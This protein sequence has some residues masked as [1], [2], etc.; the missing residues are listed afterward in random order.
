[1]DY[2]ILVERREIDGSN[3]KVN[4]GELPVNSA[5]VKLE[6]SRAV[7]NA[8]FVTRGGHDVKTGDIISFISDDLPV[9]NLACAYNFHHNLRDEGGYNIDGFRI[10]G[11]NTG[12]NYSSDG[13]YLYSG[14]YIEANGLQS[15]FTGATTVSV[16]A[17]IKMV[18]DNTDT[19]IVSMW[20]GTSND[21]DKVFDIHVNGSSK[22]ELS[23]RSG[24]T[25]YITTGT[26]TLNQ[27]TLYHV[28][29]T[30]DGSSTTVKLYLNGSEE[31]SDSSNPSSLATGTGSSVLFGIYGDKSSN[32]FIGNLKQI[33]VYSDVL[34]SS[35]IT[36]LY[37]SGTPVTSPSTS[38]LVSRYDL[39]ANAND[40]QGSNNGT[41][42]GET[43]ITTYK[44]IYDI[45]GEST[46]K[47]RGHHC[48]DCTDDFNY[49]LVD[50][51]AIYG[52]IIRFKQSD[53]EKNKDRINFENGREI[54]IHIRTPAEDTFSSS[55]DSSQVI[56]SRMDDDGGFEI[57]LKHDLSENKIY[58]VLKSRAKLSS[59][60][61][62]SE[63]GFGY[64]DTL[65]A[66]YEKDCFIRVWQA[67][68]SGISSGRHKATQ[69]QVDNKSNSRYVYHSDSLY[70]FEQ[71]NVTKDIYLGSD[72]SSQNV[73][74]GKIFAVRV[75][76][77]A[78][79]KNLKGWG[80]E[81]S[82]GS[83]YHSKIA[84]R[85][86]PLS[87]MK[88]GGVVSDIANINGKS[89][90]NAIGHSGVFLNT[91]VTAD[92]FT[93][94]TS[95]PDNSAHYGGVYNYNSRASYIPNTSV[96]YRTSTLLNL[97]LD[98]IILN[99]NTNRL[100]GTGK[101]ADWTDTSTTD[102]RCHLGKDVPFEFQ[103]INLTST[104]A[105]VSDEDD[106]P[107]TYGNPNSQGLGYPLLSDDNVR[108]ITRYDAGGKLID[109]VRLLATLGN[110][111]F[112]IIESGGNAG[113]LKTPSELVHLYGADQFQILPRKVLVFE[114]SEIP[115][116]TYFSTNN[117]YRIENEGYDDNSDINQVQVFADIKPR[118][119]TVS[120][121][122]E[123]DTHTYPVS[124]GT[125][126]VFNVRQ[127][128]ADVAALDNVHFVALERIERI[129]SGSAVATE[130]ESWESGSIHADG[131]KFADG[132]ITWGS[133]HS[134]S[135]TN[136]GIKFYF[137]VMD[138]ENDDGFFTIKN[139][140][141]IKKNGLKS[142]KFIIPQILDITTLT[143][144][145]KRILGAKAFPNRKVTLVVPRMVNALGVGMTTTLDHGNIG[146]Y[147]EEFVVKKITYHFPKGQTVVECGDFAY[148]VMDDISKLN[149]NINT[150]RNEVT[151]TN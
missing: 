145:A 80:G 8:K 100:D 91:E 28:A 150:F 73:F 20:G 49:R 12:I 126:G 27:D 54:H 135:N 148:D 130:M 107:T 52:Q 115:N 45:E 123:S 74:R 94:G 134:A 21:I 95:N 3:Y 149:E 19:T 78:F 106:T 24:S 17:W 48:L 112:K 23:L 1:M 67:E 93:V 89:M 62:N 65:T 144:L 42:S 90:I 113:Q 56:F 43:N 118:T 41:S 10:D 32:P 151:D 79:D 6:G 132:K 18:G 99:Y 7:D 124:G 138:Y 46:S 70:K 47:Y 71:Y 36:T 88:F 136:T 147:N 40:S 22:L 139:D 92:M 31:A 60:V 140:E 37:N 87:T 83:E 4:R 86:L 98:D 114:S 14:D 25:N 127:Y 44:P 11:T 30:Y 58:A 63:S 69:I 35:E 120:G 82:S 102:Q 110:K 105:I 68:G 53:R 64:S 141:L 142:K 51:V 85:L 122:Y 66:G 108:N 5:I 131:Y 38:G 15:T 72:S 117:G 75:Y 57:S 55:A 128:F 76:N 81:N 33:L 137:R 129:T 16:S 61:Q 111:Q 59:T 146:L 96:P 84:S 2:K 121:L 109:T 9:D 104:G 50:G 101:G 125:T 39:T 29:F 103:Y 77:E 26:T 34:T 143:T 116:Q 133:N 13:I 97:I 119:R